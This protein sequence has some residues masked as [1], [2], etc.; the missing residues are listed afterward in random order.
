VDLLFS[1]ADGRFSL[2]KHQTLANDLCKLLK[3]APEMA[4]AAEFIVRHCHYHNAGQEDSRIGFC[5]T[6]YVTGYGDSE[7]EARQRWAIALKLV[8]NATIQTAEPKARP[9]TH[10]I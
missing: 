8:Q 10:R 2:E 5:M 7:E 3:R 6:A 4:A 9:S 1:D